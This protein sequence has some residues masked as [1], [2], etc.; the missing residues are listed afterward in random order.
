MYIASP[1]T[2]AAPG[3]VYP[4]ATHNFAIHG[5]PGY[6]AAV[7]ELAEQRVFALFDRLKG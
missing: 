5:V 6:D 1:P 3:L 2:A 4:G 7:A